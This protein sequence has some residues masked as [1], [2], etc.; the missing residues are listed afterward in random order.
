LPVAS[1]SPFISQKSQNVKLPEKSSLVV[2]I[3]QKKH[4]KQQKYRPRGVRVQQFTNR[5]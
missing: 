5:F 3:S 1:L 4:E 2:L